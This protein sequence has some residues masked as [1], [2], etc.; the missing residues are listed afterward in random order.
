MHDRA[1][2]LACVETYK[3][4]FD[5]ARL[6]VLLVDLGAEDFPVL[7]ASNSFVRLLRLE[8]PKIE[9]RS[10]VA[11]VRELVGEDAARETRRR[12]EAGALASWDAQDDARGPGPSF[13]IILYPIACDS[14][15]NIGLLSFTRH[16]SGRGRRRHFPKALEGIYDQTPGFI[17]YGEGPE[18]RFLFANAAYKRFVGRDDLEGLSVAEALP[19]IVA[20]G[21]VAILDEVRR[22]GVP[23]RGENVRLEMKDG[24]SGKTVVRFAD[25]VYAPVEDE[26]GEIVGIFCEGYDVTEREKAES[27]LRALQT[28]LFY[29]TRVNAMGTIASTLAHELNQPLSAISNYSAACLRLLDTEPFDEERVRE[30]LRLI[31]TASQ[32]AGQT[33]AAIRRM[34][35]RRAPKTQYVSL[36]ATVEE[37]INLVR[38][39][40][41]PA[42]A[43]NCSIPAELMLEVDP[44]QLQQVMI[45]LLRNGCDA[46]EQCARKTLGVVAWPLGDSIIVSVT[47]SGEGIPEG[48]ADTIFTWS[49]SDKDEGLGLGLAI[50]R[51][52]VEAHGGRIWVE[53]SGPEG[54]DF[55]LSLP[56]R[57][58]ATDEPDT[59]KY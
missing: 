33:I 8:R 42:V 12:L 29:A 28:E 46:V 19:E 27:A 1:K 32:R 56:C 18:H 5:S 52:I 26:N 35:A 6:P 17:A 55:R 44:V 41:P 20:Q 53:Q 24:E 40:C 3:R 13:G 34:V 30:G 31:E 22:T 59:I 14:R 50:S 47:D 37:A 15:D 11:L 21:F 10:S 48:E 2:T 49:A 58:R 39:T 25:F 43:I 36:R 23:F 9:G 57:S 54:T 7:F 51:T 4:H 45:N 38:T 16:D